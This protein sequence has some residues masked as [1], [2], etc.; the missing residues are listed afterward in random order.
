MWIGARIWFL[1]DHEGHGNL[2]S[3]TPEGAASSPHARTRTTTCASRTRT[4]AQ[5]V[6]HAGADLYVVDAAAGSERKL[7]IG[8]AGPRAGRARRFVPADAPRRGR[9]TCI[10]TATRSRASRAGGLFTTGLWDGAPA[11]LGAGSGV[12][13]RLARWLPDGKRLVALSDEGGEESARRRVRRPR[14]GRRA[15]SRSTWAR[16]R[17][18]G[19]AGGRRPRRALEP[20]A[21]A[22]RRRPR[23]GDRPDRRPHAASTASRA[24]PG[25]PTDAGSPSGCRPRSAPA[26]SGCWDSVAARPTT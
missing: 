8:G 4:A 1:S 10:P 25:P 16:A 3:G 13:H 22:D 2:Y 24:W 20:A 11:R 17:P 12:R 26:P 18:R 9:A 21:G 6:H 15:A 5:V 7:E 23:R 14:D 19:R